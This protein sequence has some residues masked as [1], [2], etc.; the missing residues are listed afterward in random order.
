MIGLSFL[1]FLVIIEITFTFIRLFKRSELL[2][3]MSFLKI[4]NFAIFLILI[5]SPIINWGFQWYM[6]GIIL[7]IQA[8]NGVMNLLRKKNLLF[9]K[10]RK[11]ILSCINNIFII[12]M[13]FIPTII[14]PQYEPINTT[15]QNEIATVS[16]TLTDE[17]RQEFFTEEDDKRKVTI[18]YWYPTG[19]GNYPLIIFS[20][21]AFGYR[22]SNYSLYE[23]LASNGYVVCSI[24]HTY[25]AFLT[26]QNDGKKVIANMDFINDAIKVTNSEIVG[27]E[28]FAMQKDWMKLRTE[29]MSFVLN[30]I[31][32]MASSSSE[33]VYTNIDLNHIGVLG[34]SM[35][36]ATAAQVG[37][38]NADVDAVVVLDGTMFGEITDFKDG[39]N[40]LTD[41][42]Y[43]KPIM[44]VYNE[45]H[46]YD[47]ALVDKEYPNSVME[48]NASDSYRVVVK[49]SG[50]MNFTDLPVVSPLLS[51]MLGNGS[52]DARYCIETTN[53]NVLKFFNFYL[54]STGEVIPRETI[55]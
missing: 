42:P 24:D 8:L 25:H 32:N 23:E 33:E 52:V 12:L 29:D 45:S 16:Y 18:Q 40:V 22:M 3:E 9:F 17:S 41:I 21:G 10:K 36:G 31:K 11:I 54:K 15:G 51:S 44:N 20:H 38:M 1:A 48:Q 26:M 6:I 39:K 7:F 28:L 50:H 35:G 47:E 34:H 37:R 2:K 46:Y 43:P 13:A 53:D 5:V 27:E 19:N 49:N 55:Q 14:F 4:F 30:Y